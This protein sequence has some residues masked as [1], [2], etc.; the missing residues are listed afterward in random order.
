MEKE[1][2]KRREEGMGERKKR[3][4]RRGKRREQ[5]LEREVMGEKGGG[6]KR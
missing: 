3:E 2:Q 4:E 1:I 6:Q 5:E